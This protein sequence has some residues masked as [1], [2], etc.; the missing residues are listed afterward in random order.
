ME[1]IRLF[2][3]DIDTDAVLKRSKDL[4]VQLDS[5]SSSLKDLKRSGDTSSETYVKMEA[6]QKSL[7]S[8]YNSSQQQLSKLIN[9][10]GKEIKTVEQG[11]NALSVINKE[12]AKQ[13]SLYGANSKQAESLSKKTL[14]L[15]T[16]LKELEK[17]VGD[18]TRNVGNYSE[19]FT[20][21]IGKTTLFGRA[22][23]TVTQILS[24]ARPVMK[25]IQSDLKGIALGYRTA[26]SGLSGMT[27][28]QKAQTVAT[29]LGSAALKIF[30]LALISTGIGALVVLLGSAVAFFSKTQ[31]GVDLTSKAMAALGAFVDVVVDRLAAFF[32][33]LVKIIQG[34][35][36]GGFDDIT[37]SVKGVGDEIAREIKLVI[38]LEN[39]MNKLRDRNIDLIT[40]QAARKK[41]IEELRLAAKDESKDLQE[42]AK[43]LQQAGDLEKAILADKLK[44]AKEAAEISQLEVDRAESTREDLEENAKVQAKVI[45]L[46]T[47]SL[48]LQRSIESE[49]QGLL[50]RSRA[51]QAAAAKEARKA[52]EQRINDS[53]KE[54]KVLLELFIAENKG[55]SQSLE[56]SLIFQE[57]I[58]D[59]RLAILQEEVEA[60]KKTAAEAELE[61][62][63]IKLSFLEAQKDLVVEFANDELQIVIDANQRRID[64]N[65]FLTTAL[66]D[67]EVNRLELIAEKRREY[68]KIRF[69]EGLIS[70]REYQNAID[71]INA[72]IRAERESLNADLK[73]QQAEKEA[74]DLENR[75]VIAQE[76]YLESLALD[77]QRLEAQRVAEIENAQKTGADINLINK[78]FAQLDAGIEE[79]KAQFKI[80]V[81]SATFGNLATILG[82][83]SAAGKAAAVAQTT[84][85]TYQS[86]TAAYKS[87]AGIPVVG[88]ALGAVAAGAAIVSGLANVKKITSTNAPK[89]EKGGL[90]SVGGKRHSEGGTKFYGEDGTQFEAEKGELIGVM[91]RR[92]SQVFMNFND[93]H[94]SGASRSSGNYFA[95]GGIV[96]RSLLRGNT[97][98]GTTINNNAANA[99]EV[100]QELAQAFS[101]M[102]PIVT[103]VK[104][105]I[106]QVGKRNSL[107]DGADF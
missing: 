47:E 12:W 79:Q 94:L 104:D 56:Q 72:E 40:V 35:F 80:G 57:S 13:A 93:S 26:T 89:F 76:N 91:N 19:G 41:Q 20:E 95:D 9:I 54:N 31:K 87:L 105:V 59:K 68:E 65:S 24:V 60:G 23:S 44:S 29:G 83:E 53:I 77:Q 97:T 92:A 36:A 81:A 14:E 48:K 99:K 69:D 32:G 3:L 58:R 78:K 74:V 88:P 71:S 25:A 51:E 27:A 107:V 61:K 46:E 90:M 98:R 22:S 52:S 16:R 38:E 43:L 34:D 17:G 55:R 18:N 42:R 30:R 66:I 100:A 33:G 103:D 102:P 4:K 63:N 96:Q 45:E 15:R 86:A 49:K 62:Y 2:E 39:R 7:R 37:N 106:D 1:T 101:A 82:K 50:K 11:R 75:K 10:Q 21:A 6:T 28:A 73:E 64:E 70:E 85:D 84:I 67:E 8:E 5:V